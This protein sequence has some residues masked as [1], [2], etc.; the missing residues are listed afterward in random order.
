MAS[1]APLL[2]KHGHTQW[3][4]DLIF[5]NNTEVFPTPNYYVQMLYGQNAGDEY[6]PGNLV[7]RDVNSEVSNHIGASIV[8]ESKTG[9]VILKLVNICR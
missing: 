4:T 3:R 5:F 6:I 7:V 9:D 8:R 2:A 1:Y